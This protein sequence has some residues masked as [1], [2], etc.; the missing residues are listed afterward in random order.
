MST[1]LSPV[2]PLAPL[3]IDTSCPAPGAVRVAVIGEIDLSTADVLHAGLLSVLSAQP[4]HRIEVDLAGVTFMD[5]VGLTVLVVVG[6]A[7]TRTGC[8]L[9]ITN[10][11]P[12]V[13]RV[14]DVTGL[15]DV[16][17][18]RFDRT[19]LVA[20]RSASASPIGPTPADVTASAGFLVT[21]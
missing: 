8:Q 1:T 18:S 11:R 7:A 15:L 21:A 19:P 10:P 14:L 12:I 13:R 17:T 16:L 20:T 6:K 4:P 9:R 2:T 5:C 3:R